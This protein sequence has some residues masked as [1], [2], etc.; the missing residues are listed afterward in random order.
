MTARNYKLNFIWVLALLAGALS[1]SGAVSAGSGGSGGR[2][3]SGSISSGTSGS[4]SEGSS[5]NRPRFMT[6]LSD[7]VGGFFRGVDAEVVAARGTYD[8]L[9]PGDSPPLRSPSGD[10]YP[11][12]SCVN[13]AT[14]LMGG[15]QRA[16]TPHPCGALQGI[17]CVHRL[18]CGQTMLG[19]VAHWQSE[20]YPSLSRQTGPC[21][22]SIAPAPGVCYIRIQFVDAVL[23]APRPGECEGNTLRVRGGGG[24]G[25]VLCGSLTGTETV[26]PVTQDMTGLFRVFHDVSLHM[27]VTDAWH[28]YSIKV[29]QLKCDQHV[30]PA[31]DLP[32]QVRGSRST[33]HPTVGAGRS[34]GVTGGAGQRAGVPDRV[35]RVSRVLEE[36]ERVKDAAHTRPRRSTA[37]G[38]NL[39]GTSQGGRGIYRGGGGSWPWLS[40]FMSSLPLVNNLNVAKKPVQP[41]RVSNFQTLQSIPGQ[42]KS[43]EIFIIRNDNELENQNKLYSQG[44][45]KFN[46]VHNTLMGLTQYEANTNSISETP[47]NSFVAASLIVKPVQ[48][49]NAYVPEKTLEEN[50]ATNVDPAVTTTKIK[51]EIVPKRLNRVSLLEQELDRRNWKQAF[52]GEEFNQTK[53]DGQSGIYVKNQLFGDLDPDLAYSDLSQLLQFTPSDRLAILQ[54]LFHDNPNIL[55]DLAH[56][57]AFT[58]DIRS[59]EKHPRRTKPGP[60]PVNQDFRANLG[61]FPT[62]VPAPVDLQDADFSTFDYSGV[63]DFAYASGPSG[64]HDTTVLKTAVTNSSAPYYGFLVSRNAVGGYSLCSAVLVAPSHALTA[65]SCVLRRGFSA[66]AYAL[67]AVFGVDDIGPAAARTGDLLFRHPDHVGVSHTVFHPLYKHGYLHNDIAVLHLNRTVRDAK[68]IQIANPSI[69]LHELPLTMM[70]HGVFPSRVLSFRAY[71]RHLS[72]ITSTMIG[73]AEC[74]DLYAASSTP[75]F[76]Y[77]EEFVKPDML[78]LVSEDATQLCEGD[79]GGP[80]VAHFGTGRELLVG[81]AS[82]NDHNCVGAHWEHMGAYPDIAVRLSWQM[83]DFIKMASAEIHFPV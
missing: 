52:S 48:E 58:N 67:R 54:R 53:N 61:P 6:W 75:R 22:F 69:D 60:S 2:S 79:Q 72:Y 20:G 47:Q 55:D 42:V 81:V 70:G 77:L 71:E 8:S 46:S 25:G 10:A 1:A 37:V 57:G 30:V 38:G 29:T 45:L 11:G 56:I 24:E 68:P 80:V 65:A 66:E 39:N 82:G 76:T 49:Q 19:R 3:G 27:D 51:Q 12:G 23:T 5:N 43:D 14:C 40:N 33:A 63:K 26:V 28:K 7:N 13:L 31:V 83:L 9:C 35:G 34:W 73:S 64:E 32:Q 4:G 78:C 41:L 21:S 17:C 15:G 62:K 36:N 74:S 59:P 50:F 18:G 44:D 16:E